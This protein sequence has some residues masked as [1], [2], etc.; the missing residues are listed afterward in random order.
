MSPSQSADLALYVHWPFCLAKCPYCDFN[1][2][3][4]TRMDGDLFAPALRRELASEA[5]RVG[6]R[7]LTS[8]FFGGGTPS[9][10]RPRAIG[11]L[12]DDA[13]RF[14]DIAPGIEI[15]L[16]VN[17]TRLALD[18]LAGFRLAGVN[19]VS[20]GVQSLDDAALRVLG[21][22]HSAAEAIVVIRAARRL[23]R[24]V[25]FDLIYTRPGQDRRKWSH[26]LRAALAIGPDHI[27]LYQ[28]T[29]EP[30]TVFEVLHRRG[31]ITL[32]EDEV[33]TAL[34]LDTEALCA[35]AGLQPYE[36]SNYARPGYE[37]RH[38]IG[39]WRYADYAG[40][41][42]GAHGRLALDGQLHATRR[43]RAPEMW[44][45]QVRRIGNG[46]GTDDVLTPEQT[47][48]EA[49]LMGLR[50]HEGIDL[51]RFRARTGCGMESFVDPVILSE[52]IAEGYLTLADSRLRAT[53]DGL[54]R[55]N[56]VLDRLLDRD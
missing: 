43:H 10:M 46:L 56:A 52:C 47:G 21:R 33:A 55:L 24:S 29:I 1:A 44:F 37:S 4:H 13:A 6:R 8:I 2:H 28:L 15:T 42:P 53:R 32:P 54:L 5:S 12:I 27:S 36:V 3:P 20:I 11:A 30:Q 17:P 48:P 49:L 23:F 18:S 26:E 34:Y 45:E 35:A 22:G 31:R 50:M 40:I 41:G 38:N 19:R 51:A 7:R 9:L 14:F 39:Y 16:E 25:S